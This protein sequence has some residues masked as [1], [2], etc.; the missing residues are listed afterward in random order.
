MLMGMDIEY[1]AGIQAI[2]ELQVLFSDIG[3]GKHEDITN[4]IENFVGEMK[5]KYEAVG[6]IQ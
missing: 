4:D 6:R 1:I 5:R 2:K 3:H